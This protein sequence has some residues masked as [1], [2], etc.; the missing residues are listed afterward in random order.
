MSESAKAAVAN[1]PA[2]S[3]VTNVPKFG[4]MAFPRLRSKWQF[5]AIVAVRTASAQ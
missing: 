5:R 2:K 4:F 3:V 1:V